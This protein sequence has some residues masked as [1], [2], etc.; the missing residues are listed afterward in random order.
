[1]VYKNNNYIIGFISTDDTEKENAIVEALKN[2]PIAPQ[3]FGCRLKDD[4]IWEIFELPKSTETDEAT[5][6][7]YIAALEDFGGEVR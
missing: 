6:A 3:G 4:L 2:V 1:M 5:E 7:D